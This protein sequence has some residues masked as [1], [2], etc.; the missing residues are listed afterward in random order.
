ME[1]PWNQGEGLQN[2]SL[3]WQTSSCIWLQVGVFKTLGT[4]LLSVLINFIALLALVLNLSVLVFIKKPWGDPMG[5]GWCWLCCWVNWCLYWQGQSC[6]SLEGEH[7]SQTALKLTSRL[8]FGVE[9]W[10]YI[11]MLNGWYSQIFADNCIV[12]QRSWLF[13]TNHQLLC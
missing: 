8:C 6:C 10:V 13:Q 12:F 2:P 1:A 7:L 4:C 3:W 11:H 5:W 9:L